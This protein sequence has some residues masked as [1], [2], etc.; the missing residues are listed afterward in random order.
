M[1]STEQGRKV[2]TD[3]KMCKRHCPHMQHFI[4]CAKE[5]LTG[6][7][8]VNSCCLKGE[9]EPPK[10]CPLILEITLLQEEQDAKKKKTTKI[11]RRKL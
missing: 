4:E 6:I 2:K 9:G 1:L 10:D 3:P 5:N 11:K 7:F 8:R